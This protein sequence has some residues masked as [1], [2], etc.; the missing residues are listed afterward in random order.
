MS[1]PFKE[2]GRRDLAQQKRRCGGPLPG[3]PFLVKLVLMLL[4]ESRLRLRLKIDKK[5]GKLLDRRC[6][7]LAIMGEIANE[8]PAFKTLLDTSSRSEM[9]AL[10]ARFSGFYYYMKILETVAR[11]LKSGEIKILD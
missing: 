5:V 1:L 4:S 10:C 6:T 11:Q 3:A 2:S 9:D 8:M 7:D